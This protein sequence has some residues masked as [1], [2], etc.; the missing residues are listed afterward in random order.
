MVATW[1]YILCLSRGSFCSMSCSHS[2]G[3]NLNK[4]SIHFPHTASL[5]IWG[6]Q[7]LVRYINVILLHERIIEAK[8]KTLVCP[9][10]TYREH[11]GIWSKYA[12]VWF[13]PQCFKGQNKG[14]YAPILPLNSIMDVKK[15]FPR[16]QPCLL[17][18]LTF[19]CQTNICPISSMNLT[20]Y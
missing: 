13:R 20:I 10:F 14:Q 7:A 1:V 19:P 4:Y 15:I 9:F 6:L 18:R 5:F 11:W 3:Y 17:Y 12:S 16:C 8:V 2:V